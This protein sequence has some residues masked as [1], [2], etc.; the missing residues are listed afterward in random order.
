MMKLGWWVREGG[1]RWYSASLAG[2]VGSLGLTS[3]H[4]EATSDAG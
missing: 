4:Q 3:C 1:D 2:E